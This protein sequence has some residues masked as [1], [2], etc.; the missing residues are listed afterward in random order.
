MTTKK[1]GGDGKPLLIHL[2]PIQLVQWF[3]VGVVYALNFVLALT[4]V[5]VV[6]CIGAVILIP[7]AVRHLRRICLAM[8]VT[9]S[10]RWQ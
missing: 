7:L 5:P 1:K 3:M 10:S 2:I 6:I 8:P 9:T 4:F